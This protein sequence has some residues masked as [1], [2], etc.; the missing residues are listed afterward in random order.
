M[1]IAFAIM[2]AALAAGLAGIGSALGTGVVGRAASGLVSEEPEKFGKVLLLQAL[3]G[4]Q[5]IYG[6]LAA[7]MAMQ[8]VGLLGGEMA[9]LTNALGWNIL[10]ACL[11]IALTG[12]VSGLY[13]GRVA[14]AA[15]GIVG[16]K[17]GELGK[18]II[19]AA[20]VETYAVLGLLITILLL[21]GIQI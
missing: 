14:A 5:G 6:F 9:T 2:G 16:K 1:G 10:F 13:Q 4:T 11:P 17:P 12:L 3:P 21:N 19:L 18:G 7:I 8:K 15:V 20:V